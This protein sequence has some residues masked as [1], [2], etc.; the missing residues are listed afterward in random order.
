VTDATNVSPAE[1]DAWRSF[2]TMRRSL[3][4]ALARNLQSTGEISA[5]DYELLIAL[6]EAPDKTM[7]A[8]DLAVR[9]GWERSRVSHQV[10]R[11][12]KRGLLE[13]TECD[14][15]GRGTWV[16]LTAAGR[17][18][19]LSS[20]RD[21]AAVIREY[22]FDVLTSEEIATLQSLSERVLATIEPAPCDDEEQT[23]D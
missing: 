18:A 14:T 8:R 16:G 4:R 13:R 19:V 3:D 7:R 12:T 21:H 9:V 5:P 20:M 22:F 1:W 10:T 11:M 6:F 2:T 17:R 15:D 23:G